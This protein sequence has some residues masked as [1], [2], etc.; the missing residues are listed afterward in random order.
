MTGEEKIQGEG[1]YEAARRFDDEERAFVKSGQVDQKARE[2]ET[3][4]DGPDGDDLERARKE[5]GEHGQ[6]PER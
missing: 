3:A 4:L 1:D 5:T 6:T 2:A